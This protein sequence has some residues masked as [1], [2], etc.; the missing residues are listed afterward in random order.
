[1]K[2]LRKA[3]CALL[4]FF[5]L[6]V[7]AATELEPGYKKE[8]N[9]MLSEGLRSTLRLSLR[10][11]KFYLSDVKQDNPAVEP[12]ADDKARGFVAFNRQYMC[13]VYFNS[14]PNKLEL[15]LSGFE[16]QTTP[17]EREPV[18]VG[19]VPLEDL[20]VTVS[21]SDAKCGGSVIPASAFDLR[22]VKHLIKAVDFG[23]SQLRPEMI[24]K[25]NPVKL[26]KGV[27]RQLWITLE[28]P[29]DALPGKYSAEITLKAGE[30]QALKIPLAVEVLPFKLVRDS[31]MQFGWFAMNFTDAAFADY[32]KHGNN[33][34]HGFPGVAPEVTGG[35]CK[36]DF[37]ELDK[38]A[39][40]VKKYG[41][42]GHLNLMSAPHLGNVEQFSDEFNSAYVDGIKQLNDWA[43]KKGIKIYFHLADEIR[44]E[45]P[46]RNLSS[47][48]K[49]VKLARQVPDA[50]LWN[51]PMR[52]NDGKVDY[53]SIADMFDILA[54]H[55]GPY[56]ARI[57]ARTR[58]LN[59]PLWFYNSGRSRASF[60]F[61]MWKNG[62]RGRIEWAY[63]CWDE[64]SSREPTTWSTC[65]AGDPYAGIVY[66]LK[67]E[68]IP[69]PNY[70][71]CSEGIDDHAYIYTLEQ[72]IKKASAGTAAQ[73]SAA[74]KAA[75]LLSA[76][77]EKTDSYC[78]ATDMGGTAD[79]N[80]YDAIAWR[81]Q[82][83]AEIVKLK[84]LSK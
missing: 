24:I 45:D 58:E 5:P 12:S 60:G 79:K 30:K 67:G 33:S 75:S 71:W 73:K 15:G 39:A 61:V 31:G 81:K 38:A 40:L 84:A 42:A 78:G 3:A 55:C 29:E 80:E 54:P 76:I 62:S 17:G 65:R 74:K 22:A 83:A 2:S 27:T 52:D 72:E 19:L 18:T 8:A 37:S 28:T 35:K 63:T 57:M 4:M 53:I 56:N 82:I 41:F 69:S 64:N 6:L 25:Q 32:A 11:D 9:E 46:S 21:V 44:E 77:K 7:S 68:L 16:I 43:K 14:N 13:P 36:I 10:I 59:K 48:S 47:A 50:V 51:D 34:I 26:Y 20:D 1:M 23:V 49:L 66:P 70:E